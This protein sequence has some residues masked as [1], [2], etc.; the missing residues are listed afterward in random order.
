MKDVLSTAWPRNLRYVVA[1][2]AIV[3]VFPSSKGRIM[4]IPLTRGV[5]YDDIFGKP[6]C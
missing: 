2:T 4:Q 5:A 6:S 1:N 3:R